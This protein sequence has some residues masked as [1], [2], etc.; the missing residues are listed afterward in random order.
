[1]LKGRFVVYALASTLLIG[2]IAVAAD[3][4]V[5]SDQEQLEQLV[6]DLT[7]G[8]GDHRTDA[9]LR[10]T[11]LSREP[12]SMTSPAGTATF[13]ESDE[14]ALADEVTSAL[15]PFTRSDLEVVQRSISVNGD[16][17]TVA[18]RAR[19]GG[20]VHDVT[21]RLARSGQGWLVTDLRAR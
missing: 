20:A 12:I 4:L 19:A 6:E 7:E 21:F 10:W 17:A 16:R 13:D 18:V 14:L 5:E 3:A 15:D 8:R 11:D 9:I 2:G 1:M